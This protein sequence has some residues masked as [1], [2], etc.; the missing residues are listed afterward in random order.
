MRVLNCNPISG[1]GITDSTARISFYGKLDSIDHIY[2]GARRDRDNNIANE[3]NVDHLF[4]GG[5]EMPWSDRGPFYISL[6]AK[7]FRDNPSVAEDIRSYDDY[8]DGMD[9]MIA[10]SP[11][12]VFRILKKYGQ[13]GLVSNCKAFMQEL[14]SKISMVDNGEV[15]FNS[16]DSI[17]KRMVKDNYNTMSK[18]QIIDACKNSEPDNVD[19]IVRLIDVR[20]DE[21]A[22]SVSANYIVQQLKSIQSEFER[23]HT[24]GINEISIE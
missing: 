18:D 23:K 6:W 2:E 19:Y 9:D 22:K 5:V 16:L 10:N 20:Y 11:A 14:K 3:F 1:N 12:R 21:F 15:T 13:N 4:I 8:D 24:Q 7:F 17:A